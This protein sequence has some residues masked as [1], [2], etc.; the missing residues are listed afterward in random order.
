M[1]GALIGLEPGYLWKHFQALVDIPRCSGKEAAVRD[2]LVG[3]A[4]EKGWG[5]DVDDVGNLVVRVP[6]TPGHEKSPTVVLQGH[7]DIVCEKNEDVDHDFTTDPI[8][9][10]VDGDVVKAKGTTLGSDNGIGIAAGLALADD[11]AV[12]HGPLEL[13]CTVEEET[14]LTGAAALDGRMLRGRILLNLDTEEEGAVYV[15]CAGGGDQLGRFP[16]SRVP[17]AEGSEAVEIRVRGLKGGHSGLDIH[18]GRGNA[19]VVLARLLDQ[20]IEVGL[21]LGV[22]TLGGGNMHNAIPREARATVRLAAGRRAAIEAVVAE[23]LVEEIEAL[24]DADPGLS[25]EVQGAEGAAETLPTAT[26]QPILHLLLEIPHGVIEMSPDIEDLVQTSNNLAVVKIDG[27]VVVVHASSR[28]SVS[29]NL[30]RVRDHICE[31]M[32]DAG[33]EIEREEAYPGWEPNMDSRL[34]ARCRQV[35]ET[36]FGAEPEIKAIHAGLECG[37]IGERIPGMDMA[38]IGPNIFFPHSPD[39]H[40]EIASVGKFWTFLVG[41]IEDLAKER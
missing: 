25:I 36:L 24:S 40:V 14:G 41:V 28:S 33:G 13:L 38:S 7:L 19:V 17:A 16:V 9:A 37:I 22:D 4:L 34:L 12:A 15:G 6:A 3:L 27:D 21:L 18:L 11:P 1:A 10:Y 2:H 31:E 35:H 20:L 23:R 5:A 30:E 26:I 29:A 39:E 8:A 32:E